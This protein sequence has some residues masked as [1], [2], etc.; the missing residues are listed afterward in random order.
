LTYQN[1]FLAVPSQTKL[2]VWNGRGGD[3]WGYL[4]QDS[5]F[6]D[7]N[8]TDVNWYFDWSTTDSRAAAAIWQISLFP[9]SPSTRS[10]EEAA[11]LIA[12]GE[13]KKVPKSGQSFNFAIDFTDYAPSPKGPRPKVYT[14]PQGGLM[15]G[16]VVGKAVTMKPPSGALQARRIGTVEQE[17]PLAHE[18]SRLGSV[19]SFLTNRQA[20]LLFRRNTFYVRLILLDAQGK[21]VGVPSNSVALTFGQPETTTGTIT[22]IRIPAVRFVQFI[23]VRPYA[24]DCMC[25]MKVARSVKC[26]GVELFKEGDYIDICAPRDH[27]I[28]DDIC[29][30]IGGFFSALGSIADW[31]VRAYNS[32]KAAVI[33]VVVDCLKG[34][35]G[36]GEACQNLVAATV[37]Y[38][39][40]AVGMPPS[41]PSFNELA[42]LGAEYLA[43]QIAR[44]VHLPED[45]AK[46][47][48]E[49]FVASV[50]SVGSVKS[51]QW[52]IAD[53]ERQ[54]K[55]AV[56]LFNVENPTSGD[57]SGSLIVH[58]ESG[59]YK[60]AV[61]PLVLGP[62]QHFKVPVVLEPVDRPD[63]WMALLPTRDDLLRMDFNR[64]FDKQKEA[65]NALSAWAQKYKTG[66]A[67]LKFYTQDGV[68][69]YTPQEE[70]SC[71][72]AA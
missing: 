9:F 25:M 31:A 17:A 32:A 22:L 39:L 15:E 68:G 24:P 40:A 7:W 3:F 11:G 19:L 54:Y 48:A 72:G 42:N 28:W 60:T 44:E 4:D 5:I 64:Y 38:G 41:L 37:D 45:A 50:Q 58:D 13:L 26:M 1:F 6:I 43:A 8:R 70:V 23:P 35:V 21:P 67:R 14:L 27:S 65:G 59:L 56:A 18:P 63:G 69:N 34:T 62:R 49:S 53:P 33:S 10:M 52:L 16:A 55:P 47:V 51:D 30:T 66:T 29:D 36:C 12:H 20:G 61:I 46:K 2:R 71:P 57:F